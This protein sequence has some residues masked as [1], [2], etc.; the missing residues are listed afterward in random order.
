MKNLLLVGPLA[1]ALA[2]CT[3]T[4]VQEVVTDGQLVCAVGQARL[5]MSTDTGAVILAKDATK[6]AVDAT[7][8][9][10]HGVAVSPPASGVQSVTVA[11]PA[12]ISIPLT[13]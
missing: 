11:L 6:R 9:L 10:L 8:A 13:S 7:C 4:Q 5:A 1:A 3:A 2:G 12:S